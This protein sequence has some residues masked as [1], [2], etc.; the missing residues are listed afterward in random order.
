MRA[1]TFEP[2][3]FASNSFDPGT[4]VAQFAAVGHA[5][6]AAAAQIS[7]ASVSTIPSQVMSSLDTVVSSTSMSAS[8]FPL[9]T[10]PRNLIIAKCK[11]LRRSIRSVPPPP[12]PLPPLSPPFLPPPAVLYP[13]CFQQPV[14][15]TRVRGVCLLIRHWQR[16]VELMSNVRGKV[17][18]ASF[19]FQI[20]QT[21]LVEF[22]SCRSFSHRAPA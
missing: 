21:L 20:Q 19:V 5:P 8:V 10:P 3:A 9:S 13:P 16:H 14:T 6:S 18:A 12:P 1:V 22:C 7:S 4:A 15:P 2:A 17:S 11:A